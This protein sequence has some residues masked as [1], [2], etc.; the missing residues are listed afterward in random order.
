VPI[1]SLAWAPLPWTVDSGLLLRN[2]DTGQVLHVTRDPVSGAIS[3]SRFPSPGPGTRIE[4]VGDFDGDGA[5]DMV[6][7]NPG[8]GE[9]SIWRVNRQGALIEARELGIDGDRWKVEAVRDW[10]GNGCDDLLL[11]R[12]G[13]GRLVV[14][15]MQFQDGLVGIQSSRPIGNTGG[16]RVVDVTQR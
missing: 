4:G 3:S 1:P 8:T 5:P 6:C 2:A 10:D 16:A 13:S 14:L 15:Y 9:L 11:S 12:G 7:R